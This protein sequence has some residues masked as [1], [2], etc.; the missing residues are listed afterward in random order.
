MVS[1]FFT[2]FSALVA[3]SIMATNIIAQDEMF[4]CKKDG[5]K[6]K[7]YVNEIDSI[8]FK[9]NG[10]QGEGMGRQDDN[11]IFFD[12]FNDFN[13]SVWTKET[14]E[15]GW[16]NRELQSYD[17][18]YVS[19]GK[20]GD[21][22]VLILTAERMNGRIV[23]GRVNSKDKKSFKYGK[24]EASIKLPST[25]NGLWPA[26]WMM[27]D[28]NNEW[29]ACGEIDIMEMG[30]EVGIL[31][32]T[33]TRHINTA[34]HYGP[35]A[36][37]HEQHYKADVVSNNLQDGNYHKYTAI[38]D[39]DKIQILYDDIL[40]H[41]FNISGN[42]YFQDNFYMLFNLAVGGMFTAIYD[43]NGITALPEGQCVMMYVDWIRIAK[44]E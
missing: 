13:E 34:I 28:N 36:N 15:A 24:I 38:W 19:V 39:Q 40:F 25:A 10:T 6:L 9:P 23:S 29:P 21:K 31:N 33:T 14:H 20:D 37:R 43:V 30:N 3:T 42:Q 11:T 4:I 16:V 5:Q 8:V 7:Y 32:N 27:G 2:S 22:S 26:F 44:S 12:D 18:A 41:T 1:K 35:D 17:P